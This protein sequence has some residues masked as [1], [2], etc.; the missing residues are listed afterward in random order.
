MGVTALFVGVLA[1]V[2]VER[3]VLNPAPSTAKAV[4]RFDLYGLEGGRVMVL[5][6]PLAIA[7]DGSRV[8]V[9]GT[10]ADAVAASPPSWKWERGEGFAPGWLS[11]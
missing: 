6:P 4:V 1:G 8:V 10:D 9:A 11:S 5:E 3:V 7:P 2:L